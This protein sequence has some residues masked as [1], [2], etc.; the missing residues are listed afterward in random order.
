MSICSNL[1]ILFIIMSYVGLLLM[2]YIRSL[3]SAL[4]VTTGTMITFDSSFDRNT[5][6]KK[7]Q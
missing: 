4:T 6:P 3:G 1:W 7:R 5:Q 2:S